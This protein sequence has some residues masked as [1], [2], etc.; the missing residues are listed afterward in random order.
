MCVCVCGVH[1]TSMQWSVGLSV[2]EFH[3]G[4][5]A[6]CALIGYI[7]MENINIFP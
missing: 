3:G 1:Y 7:L 2:L 5:A 4:D 6:R